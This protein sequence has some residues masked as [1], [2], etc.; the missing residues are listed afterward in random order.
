MHSTVVR[1]E[2]EIRRGERVLH[3]L[4]FS[5]F[6]VE[7]G[8]IPVGSRIEQ[9]TKGGGEFMGDGIE[10]SPKKEDRPPRVRARRN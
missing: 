9:T 7:S 10:R 1:C 3:I 6:V 8:L 4:R 5:L 2:Q